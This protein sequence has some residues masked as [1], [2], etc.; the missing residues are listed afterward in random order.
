MARP[1]EFHGNWRVRAMP[2]VRSAREGAFRSRTPGNGDG[3][4]LGPAIAAALPAAIPSWSV[5]PFTGR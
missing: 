3:S 4:S 1:Q 2:S 5:G